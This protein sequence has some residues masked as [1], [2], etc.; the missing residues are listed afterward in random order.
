MYTE[1]C[2]GCRDELVGGKGMT[3]DPH[4]GF[5]EIA[6]RYER[7]IRTGELAPG[8]A[9]P[10]EPKLARKLGVTRTTL[11]RAFA[12]LVRKGLILKKPGQGTFVASAEELE[13]RSSG[14]IA[15][16]AQGSVLSKLNE[17]GDVPTGVMG[18]AGGE[19]YQI[20]E[21]VTTT[22]A[23]YGRMT[24]TYY[25]HGDSEEHSRASH[26]IKRNG[27]AGII[28]LS[29]E[30]EDVDYVM[31][32]G[33]PTVFVDSASA[34]CGADAVHATNREGMAEATRYI[35]STTHG[36]V[37]FVG[38]QGSQ[39]HQPANPH[40]ER[41]EGFMDACSEMNRSVPPSHYFFAE[42]HVNGG[43][44]IARDIL[45]LWPR[46]AGIVCS[47]DRVAMGIIDV[48]RNEGISVPSDLSVVAFGGTLI[49]LMVIP[50]IS[51]VAPDRLR[52]GEEAVHLLEKRLRTPGRRPRT[53]RVPTKLCLRGSTL[54]V[55]Q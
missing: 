24:R 7:L 43:R 1:G 16:L 8:Q 9:L 15:V 41:L 44:Q 33:L 49:S 29:F 18:A 31:S 3:R 28:A 40:T 39:K 10:T 54:R 14:S 51:T 25:L 23:S 11:R 48:F 13:K 42:V 46:P 47:D 34:G 52:M 55:P 30:A 27:D 12:I 6:D 53:V 32:L 2:H 4:L 5:R 37:A 19:H 26:A 17:P 36:P 22:L 38:S 50:T 20:L 35:L 45:C 21:G